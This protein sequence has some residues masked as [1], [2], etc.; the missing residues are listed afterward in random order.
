MQ[1]QAGAAS[2]VEAR[3]QAALPDRPGRFAPLLGMLADGL[4]P[5]P[6]T[7]DFL[8]PRRRAA[9][10]SRRNAYLLAGMTAVLLVLAA[11]FG[12]RWQA[13]RLDDEIRQLQAD[14]KTWETRASKAAGV[15]KAASEIEA[16][17]SREVI[18]LDQLHWFCREFPPAQEAMLTQLRLGPSRKGGEMRLDGLARNVDTLKA[19]EKALHDK[20]HEV[21]GK[22]SSQGSPQAPYSLR[23]SS[24][25]ILG[26]EAP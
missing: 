11:L 19:M 13:G 21:I 22:G 14:T 7:I 15:E 20:G 1:G 8:N 6:H 25:L 4:E 12:V 3:A 17:T 10:T 24:S 23:F 2:Q 5:V 16:W 9:P 26:K 18:W